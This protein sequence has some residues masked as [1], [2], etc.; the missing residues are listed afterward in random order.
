M[1]IIVSCLPALSGLAQDGETLGHDFV[2]NQPVD[3][4]LACSGMAGWPK[5]AVELG[6]VDEFGRSEACALASSVLR[7]HLHVR[8]RLIVFCGRTL[9]YST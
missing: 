8:G 5:F 1:I 2:F 6:F 4:T 3:V 9:C 7:P